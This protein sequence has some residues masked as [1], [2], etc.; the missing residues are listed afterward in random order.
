MPDPDHLSG[1][2]P[3]TRPRLFSMWLPPERQ[4]FPCHTR[5]PAMLLMDFEQPLQFWEWPCP[6]AECDRL[7]RFTKRDGWLS[8][9]PISS[10]TGSASTAQHSNPVN[11]AAVTE[12]LI[13]EGRPAA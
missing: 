4:P 11:T 6:A 10:M 1:R 2:R 12:R 7:Y 9:E 5:M 13:R 3:L 8:W